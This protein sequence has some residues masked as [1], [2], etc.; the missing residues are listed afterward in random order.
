VFFVHAAEPNR[1]L[2]GSEVTAIA[3]WPVNDL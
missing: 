2:V 1:E 3:G